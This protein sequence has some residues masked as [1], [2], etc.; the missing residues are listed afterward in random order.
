VGVIVAVAGYRTFDVADR[1]PVILLDGISQLSAA[2]LRSLTEYLSDA[3]EVLVTTAYPEAGTFDG[4]HISPDQW[5]T[6]S[7]E[8]A[9]TA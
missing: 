9:P 3:A 8:E 2:N 7:D 4:N 6:V 5:D 1:V